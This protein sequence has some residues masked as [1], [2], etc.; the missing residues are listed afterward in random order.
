LVREID[1]RLQGDGARPVIYQYR[2]RICRYPRVRGI[3]VMVN[4]ILNGW[5]FDEARL[6]R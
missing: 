4:S 6:D 2:Q 1:R 5:R 3:T